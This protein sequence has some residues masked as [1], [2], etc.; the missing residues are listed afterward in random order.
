MAVLAEVL[1]T[2]TERLTARARYVTEFAS[3]ASH[4]LKSP[5]TAIRGAAELLGQHDDMPAPQRARFVQNI[6]EDAERMERLVTR[7]LEL[8]RAESEAQE[9][10]EELDVA[11]VVAAVLERYAP[12]VELSFEDP[13]H[14]L[15]IAEQHLRAVL[16]N[17]VE[18]AL[19]HGAGKPV[20]VR[21]S[22]FG[23][24][25]VISVRD[26]GAGISEANQARLFQRFFTTERDRGGT[27]LGLSIVKAIAEARGGEVSAQS[28]PAGSTFRVVL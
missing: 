24:Q 19:R 11:T 4:E 15:Q 6:A 14:S 13:P 2:M 3:N 28:G 17:L 12:R 26:H 10:A 8:A 20:Q 5:I 7:M 22:S 21:V 16:V 9:P 1:Q 23:S 25:L 27:G 18:N